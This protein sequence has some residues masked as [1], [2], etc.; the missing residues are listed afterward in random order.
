MS[1]GGP[2]FGLRCFHFNLVA[3]V[4][5]SNK[6]L[7]LSNYWWLSIGTKKNIIGVRAQIGLCQFTKQPGCFC[8]T[9]RDFYFST[10]IHDPFKE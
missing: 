3:R 7:A 8:K 1:V 5:E 2:R 6:F 9:E 10:S 4:Q